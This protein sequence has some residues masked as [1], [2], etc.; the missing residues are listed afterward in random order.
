MQSVELLSIAAQLQEIEL[1]YSI[2]TTWCYNMDE[3]I[4]YSSS[5]V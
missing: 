4:S 2:K 5:P 3:A 1:M